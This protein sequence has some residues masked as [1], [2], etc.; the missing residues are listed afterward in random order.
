MEE[1]SLAEEAKRQATLEK[2]FNQHRFQKTK[3]QAEATAYRLAGDT[4]INSMTQHLTAGKQQ[5]VESAKLVGNANG[6][7]LLAQA[8]QLIK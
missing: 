1:K 5:L 8:R 2:Q 4:A 6:R 3:A 7:N